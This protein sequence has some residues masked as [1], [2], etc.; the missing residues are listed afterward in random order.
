M[1]WV[2]LQTQVE[3]SHDVIDSD[4]VIATLRILR[5]ERALMRHYAN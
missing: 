3:E 2:V 1:F 4:I 5:T